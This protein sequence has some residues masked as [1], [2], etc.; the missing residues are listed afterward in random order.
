VKWSGARVVS[1]TSYGARPG[2]S[3][4]R[5]SRHFAFRPDVGRVISK[6][7]GL[8]THGSCD[9][10]DPIWIGGSE[11]KNELFSEPEKAKNAGD[12]GRSGVDELYQPSSHLP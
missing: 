5:R 12:V 11:R 9:A 10:L 7:I 8:T 3:P 4:S 1:R 6:T 2:G